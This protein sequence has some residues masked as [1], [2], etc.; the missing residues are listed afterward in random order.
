[1]AQVGAPER[2]PRQR[3]SGMATI[4][5]YAVSERRQKGQHV[6]LRFESRHFRA[7]RRQLVD[8]SFLRLQI[9]SQI[10]VRSF[11][12]LVAKSEHDH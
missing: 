10:D 9:G 3:S 8:R 1:M 2:D 11:N 4:R 5:Y 7:C 6:I 12:A